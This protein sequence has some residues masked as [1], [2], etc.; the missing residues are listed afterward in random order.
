MREADQATKP[1][2]ATGGGGSDPT[3]ESSYASPQAPVIALPKGGGAIRGIG[4][5]F[6]ANPVTG[7]GTMS[8][9]ITTTPGR[10]EVGPSPS[11]SYESGSGNG[12]CG[13]VST[14]ALPADTR[15]ND[16]GLP[17]YLAAEA[18]DAFVFP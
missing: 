8:I 14:L 9:P 16:T 10:S 13:F 1:A 4:E 3:P 6:A 11:L 2:P 17:R 15:K 18:P 7:T 5:K 12:H